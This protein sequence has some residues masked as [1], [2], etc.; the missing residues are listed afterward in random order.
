MPND[1]ILHIF[2]MMALIEEYFPRPPQVQRSPLP[3]FSKAAAFY[4]MPTGTQTQVSTSLHCTAFI[5]IFKAQ[6]LFT[7]ST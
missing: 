7:K 3:H 4:S 2:Q 5:L 6:A 1:V